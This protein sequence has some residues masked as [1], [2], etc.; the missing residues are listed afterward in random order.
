MLL[1]LATAFL[2][3]LSNAEAEPTLEFKPGVGF[4]LEANVAETT[5]ELGVVWEFQGTVK[6][7][8]SAT[9]QLPKM[10]FALKNT[11]RRELYRWT[12]SLDRASLE[13]NEKA[14][15]HA[16]VASPPA[17]SSIV[18]ISLFNDD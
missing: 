17:D 1:I 2:A 9:I 18:E 14:P 10:R 3:P 4:A 15:F 6:N 8:G 5:D 7:T 12:V 13:P 11:A 16:E